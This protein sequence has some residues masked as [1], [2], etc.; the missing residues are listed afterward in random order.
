MIQKKCPNCSTSI[1]FRAGE[2]YICSHCKST[3][4]IKD[5]NPL[6]YVFLIL[7]YFPIKIAYVGAMTA[8]TIFDAIL[9]IIG[10]T[11]TVLTVRYLTT[12]FVV[13]KDDNS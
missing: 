2:D 10:V 6:F 9:I 8:D 4:T 13:S 3:L 12:T 7:F 11:L 1:P 5:G